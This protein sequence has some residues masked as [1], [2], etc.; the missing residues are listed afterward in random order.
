MSSY[1]YILENTRLAGAEIPPVLTGKE[2]NDI[3][4][5]ENINFVSFQF[6]EITSEKQKGEAGTNVKRIPT[7]P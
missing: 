5:L 1:I 2:K 3:I 4:K 6:Y 7:S